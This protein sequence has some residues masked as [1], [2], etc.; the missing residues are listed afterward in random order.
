MVDD[1]PVFL[2][3]TGMQELLQELEHLRTV[4]RPEVA[5]R[6]GQ[7]KEYGDISENGEYEDAKNEQAFVE[8]RI[9]TL[10]S[11]LNRARLIKEDKT[12]RKNGTVRLGSKVTT[13]DNTNERETWMLVS[14]AEANATHGRISDESLVGRALLGKKVGDQVSVQAP[15]GLMKFKV[16]SVE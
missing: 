5:A 10:E 12:P 3:D 6:I 2:T 15:A 4:K 8:G 1:K 9:R 7:A 16:V 13:I 14:S 11:L